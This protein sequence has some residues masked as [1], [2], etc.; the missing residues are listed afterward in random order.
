MKSQLARFCIVTAT[1]LA[2]VSTPAGAGLVSSGGGDF[3]AVPLWRALAFGTV[4]FG[5]NGGDI[6][7]IDYASNTT[8][9]PLA[10]GNTTINANGATLVGQGS[11]AYS[12]F[13][14]GRNY[15]SISVTNANVN[16]TYYEVAG[17]GSA[18]SVRF[19]DPSAAAAYATFSWRVSGTTNNPS[20]IQPNCVI[21]FTTCFPT[22]TGRLDFGA[23]TNP[24]TNWIN[25]FDDPTN[26]LD[27]IT[28]FGSG[29]YTYNLPIANLGD[30][31]NLYYWSS[32]YTQVNAGDVPAHSNFTLSAQY[33]NTFLL[34]NVQL[35]DANNNLIP[36][37]NMLDLTQNQVVFDQSGRLAPVL[38]APGVPEPA[39]L[40]LLGLGLAAIGASRR[41]R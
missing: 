29:L 27:S 23:S 30:V 4:N 36:V 1:A 38:P 37:W 12:G 21:N 35:F 40:A 32:A 41:K 19:F 33:F 8:P 6:N 31:I 13:Y 7:G 28:R 3:G 15:A 16:D 26:A 5:S 11:S 9:L 10:N 17:Q 39:T 24:A 25:L 18:T 22:A 34:E 2:A 20:N 14:A